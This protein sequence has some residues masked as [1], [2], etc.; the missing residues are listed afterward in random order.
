MTLSH[1]KC[2]QLVYLCYISYLKFELKLIFKENKVVFVV[3]FVESD[4]YSKAKTSFWSMISSIFKTPQIFGLFPDLTDITVE[5][6]NFG[7][8]AH[9]LQVNCCNLSF[10]L[11]ISPW[12]WITPG[13]NNSRKRGHDLQANCYNLSPILVISHCREITPGRGAITCR[14][15][16]CNLSLTLE[17]SP[18]SWITLESRAIA[19]LLQTSFTYV[20]SR[21]SWITPRMG[22]GW[23]NFYLGAVQGRAQSRAQK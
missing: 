15:K 3:F 14:T 5:L 18:W 17:I 11:V 8:R 9:G 19:C 20:I 12:S 10:T 1:L 4:I 13:V 16:C 2:L 6:S 21:L 23:L 7:K 22:R